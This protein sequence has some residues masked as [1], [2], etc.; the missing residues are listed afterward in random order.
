MHNTA[1]ILENNRQKLWGFDIQTG[2]LISARRPDLVIIKKK[3]KTCKIVD[4]TVPADNRIKLK[5]N[6]MKDKYQGIALGI[7]NL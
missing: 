6:E 1:D 7:K 3:K 5:E 4:F 2:H